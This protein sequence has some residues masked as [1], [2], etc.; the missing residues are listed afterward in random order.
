MDFL[1]DKDNK[2]MKIFMGTYLQYVKSRSLKTAY[3]KEYN[4]LSNAKMYPA[5]NIANC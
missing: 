4:S 2:P 3:F 1:G 5:L